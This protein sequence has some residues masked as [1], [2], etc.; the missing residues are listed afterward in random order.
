MSKLGPQSR[1]CYEAGFESQCSA[2][3]GSQTH[4]T[5]VQPRGPSANFGHK[6][7]IVDTR[8]AILTDRSVHYQE[9]SLYFFYLRRC[10]ILSD[11]KNG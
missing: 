8:L 1:L 2:D 4:M 7:N 6:A 9:F 10:K 3:F 11:G 5:S